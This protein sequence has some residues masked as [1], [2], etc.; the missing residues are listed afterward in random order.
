M[1]PM[2]S[3]PRR[4]R[5]GARGVRALAEGSAADRRVVVVPCV[6]SSGGLE[7]K[8]LIRWR[9][10]V[11]HTKTGRISFGRYTFPRGTDLRLIGR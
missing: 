11:A 6:A 5:P 7:E 4:M 9:M 1:S 2:P 3:Y 8:G 10:R